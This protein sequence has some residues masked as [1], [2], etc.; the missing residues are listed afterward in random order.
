[1]V[2]EEV[3]MAVVTAQFQERKHVVFE[4]RG[5]SFTNSR[6]RGED[7]PA[8]FT[9][10]ELMMISLGNCSLGWLLDHEPLAAAE[11]MSASA[12]L[13][14][15]VEPHPTRIVRISAHYVVEVT[16]AALLEQRSAMIDLLRSCPMG[17]TL[18]SVEIDVQLDLRVIPTAE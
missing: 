13:E 17:N 9:S 3:A 1:M 8:G 10:T 7:G 12:S 4:S 18:S 6:E 14:P 16:D 2:A 5:R 11:V 15:M